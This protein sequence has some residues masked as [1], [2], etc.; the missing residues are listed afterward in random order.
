[1]RAGISRESSSV[2]RKHELGERKICEKIPYDPS[3]TAELDARTIR[4]AVC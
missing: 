1:M 3:R 4:A 2:K